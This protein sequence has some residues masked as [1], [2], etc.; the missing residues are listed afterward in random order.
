MFEFYIKS[1]KFA[2]REEKER[3]RV[4]KGRMGKKEE[5]HA[6]INCEHILCELC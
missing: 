5:T 4:G 6:H 2:E 3:L 1:L